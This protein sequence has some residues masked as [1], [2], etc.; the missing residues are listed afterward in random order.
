MKT[1]IISVIVPVYKVEKYLCECVNSILVQTFSNF[2][3]LLI[4]D[5][6]PD[7]S[8]AICD[9]YALKD[10]RVRVF[11]KPNGGVSSARNLGLDKAKGEWV[12]FIDS[13]DFVSPTFLKGLYT[14]IANGERLD[15]V[16]GGCTNWKNG[17][18]AG[19]NQKYDYYIGEEHEILF[20]K[21]RGLAISKLFRL[22]A[23]KSWS[24]GKGLHF[25][26]EMK[27]AED[28]A[29][30]LDYILNVSRYAFVPEIGYY[31]RLDNMGSATKNSNKRS[32]KE[33]RYTFEKLYST[34]NK[35]VV[36]HNLT[37]VQSKFRVE[38]RAEEYAE[39]IYTICTNTRGYINFKTAINDEKKRI[40]YNLLQKVPFTSGYYRHT[41]L[42][43]GG[44]YLSYYLSVRIDSLMV[45]VK[46]II[47]KYKI[48]LI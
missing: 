41:K 13:D 24:N 47:K 20:R 33:L 38:Q 32:S 15:F 31:Y 44:H 29:F 26:E 48:Q 5:G 14:P 16:Q 7:N 4:D 1:P 8:G 46:S 34:T 10:S 35:Y 27:I 43:V 6:S 30:T 36:I 3:L 42:L 9:R 28:M 18:S 12:T 23:I 22:E 19:I 45:I 39:L 21:F 17:R 2:E 11:H 25:D 40:Y 37:D